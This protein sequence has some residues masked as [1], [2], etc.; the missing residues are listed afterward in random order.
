M[1]RAAASNPGAARRLRRHLRTDLVE[2]AGVTMIL[3]THDLPEAREVADRILLLDKGRVAALGPFDEVEP[4][5]E[6]VFAQETEADDEEDGLVSLGAKARAFLLRDLI[7]EASY[8]LNFVFQFVGMLFTVFS[9]YFLSKLI[10]RAAVP[11]LAP[12]GGDY[13]A[14]ALTGVAFTSFLTVSLSTFADRIRGAQMLGTL[15][16][17][18]VTR[19]GLVAL[20]L[21]SSL[22]PL[23]WTLLRVSLLVAVGVIFFDVPLHLSGVPVTAVVLLLTVISIAGIGILGA[24][25][26]MVFKRFE[27][28]TWLVGGLSSSSAASSIRSR[29]SRTGS[30][31]CRTSCPSPTRS[32]ASA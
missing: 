28:V 10:G 16:A 6:R 14:F 4:E 11:H 32:R 24:S 18:L 3:A 17:M 13:F 2:A 20:M 22:F 21:Y 26:I 19:T 12:Y 29:S 9:F 25:F 7:Q 30:S 1:S 5:V 27:P 8:R 15:E 23:L 31:R